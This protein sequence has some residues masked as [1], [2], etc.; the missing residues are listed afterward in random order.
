MSTGRPKWT[1]GSW[2]VS[3]SQDY[4][5]GGATVVRDKQLVV[6]VITKRDEEEAN[7]R[8]I[9]AAPEMVE[10]LCGLFKECCMIHKHWGESNNAVASDTA[11]ANARAA[12]RKARGED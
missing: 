3:T 10:A 4:F 8:L 6:A 2:H 12:L 11:Q 5:P 7:A 9:A 1:P